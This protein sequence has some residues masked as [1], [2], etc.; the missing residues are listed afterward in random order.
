MWTGCA[1]GNSTRIPRSAP[2]PANGTPSAIRMPTAMTSAPR[3]SP[4]GRPATKT[5]TASPSTAKTVSAAQREAAAS[6][7]P[8]ARRSSQNSPFAT[9]T[10]PA[11][12]TASTRCAKTQ[13]A[14]QSRLRTTPAARQRSKQ[15]S[16]TSSCPY[17]A[18]ASPNRQS[19][20]ARRSAPTT[21]SA[22]LMPIVTTSVFR[23]S[24]TATSVTRTPTVR[25]T[26]AQT[27]SAAPRGTA[28]INLLTARPGTA[29]PRLA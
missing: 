25:P 17:S 23:T 28:A 13:C 26:T 4:M 15:T 29:N 16:V 12:A 19:R 18:T 5:P 24:P 1:T 21:A 20:P 27:A 6:W 7:Q 11:R 10:P 8:T 2:K 3:T 9:T 14:T 22:T